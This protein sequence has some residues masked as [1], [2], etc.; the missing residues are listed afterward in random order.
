MRS[1]I[2]FILTAAAALSARGSIVHAARWEA[3][4]SL[5]RQKPIT[6]LVQDKPRIYFRVTPQ[7][8][9]VISIDGPSRLRIVSRAEMPAGKNDVVSY[10]LR[11][12]EGGTV[13]DQNDTESSASDRVRFP[14]SDRPLGKS[15]RMVVDIPAGKHQIS[16]EVERAQAV[17]V[18]LFQGAPGRGE[19]PMVTLTPIDAPRSVTVTEGEKTIPYY[20]TF[21]GKPIRLRVVGP[22]TLDL[23]TRLDFDATM[24]GERRYR[25][26]VSDQG[27]KVREFDFKTTKSTTA[28]YTNL[29]DRVPSKFDRA[30]LEIGQGT[31]EI[32]IELLRPPDAACEVHARIP[33]PTAGNEE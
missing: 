33:Q 12:I 28:A 26:V 30:R 27:R 2:L 1:A 32:T 7:A 6:V 31:H 8:P 11:A 18:R 24:R 4:E 29:R 13:L 21:M 17:L 19:E 15:R 22:T 14:D 23:T 16:L 10:R 5:P 9:L 20:T 25:L 3:I